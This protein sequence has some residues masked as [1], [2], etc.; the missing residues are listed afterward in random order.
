MI[1]PFFSQSIKY[2]CKMSEIGADL[3]AQ[4]AASGSS[5]D[6]IT[7]EAPRGRAV[8]GYRRP[9]L[10]PRLI[11][12][13]RFA[14]RSRASIGWEVTVDAA[15]PKSEAG[16]KL[17]RIHELFKLQAASPEIHEAFLDALLFSH[18]V[19]GGSVLQPGRAKFSLG[20]EQHYLDYAEVVRYLGPDLRRFFRA[21]AD[22]TRRV[23]Q[24]VL[25]NAT[26]PDDFV[27]ME[28]ADLL[29]A[30]AMRRG[31]NRH[32]SLAHDTADYCTGLSDAENAA[33][34]ASKALV[35]GSTPNMA[36]RNRARAGQSGDPS[37][38][39]MYEDPTARAHALADHK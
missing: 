29:R 12:H 35:F 34:V 18:T 3:Y 28:K 38:G 22:E 17:S 5:R 4:A 1:H 10:D 2:H 27:A 8:I 30:A 14:A 11:R 19:N 32:P 33:L 20:S 15:M 7:V 31:M 21:F 24:N 9:L 13:D 23:N 37:V 25:D 6:G 36:D 39:T 16:D 26:D